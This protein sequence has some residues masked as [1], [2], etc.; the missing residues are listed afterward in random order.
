[1]PAVFIVGPG[2][3][4]TL[5]ADINTANSNGQSTPVV[6]SLNAQGLVV[7]AQPL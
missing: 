4:N 5:I 7:S 3:V 6:E 1:M 2:D